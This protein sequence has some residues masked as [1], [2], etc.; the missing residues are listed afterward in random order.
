[1][2]D[3]SAEDARRILSGLSPV[4]ETLRGLAERKR[5]ARPPRIPATGR[6]RGGVSS[7][8]D[9]DGEERTYS[10]VERAAEGVERS[11]MQILAEDLADAFSDGTPGLGHFSLESVHALTE[12]EWHRRLERPGDYDLSDRALIESLVVYALKPESPIRRQAA[13][14][15]LERA[16]GSLRKAGR[17]DDEIGRAF[18]E[19]SCALWHVLLTAGITIERAVVLRDAIDALLL[20]GVDRTAITSFSP[21][22]GPLTCDSPAVGTR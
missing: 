2:Q 9:A 4:L 5:R 7:G 22:L 1:M 8:S 12:Q 3:L 6:P 18:C 20:D 11:Q 14:W 17:S 15:N 16:R 19:L 21:A 10:P 13:E